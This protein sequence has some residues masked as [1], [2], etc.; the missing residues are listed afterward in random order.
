MILQQQSKVPRKE[1]EHQRLLMLH[2]QDEQE[3]DIL[4]SFDP[5]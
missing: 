2:I 1:V 5:N 4:S 3:D